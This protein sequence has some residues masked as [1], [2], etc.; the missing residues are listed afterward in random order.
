MKTTTQKLIIAFALC[1]G[2]FSWQACKERTV[3]GTDLIPPVDNIHTF[4][5]TADSFAIRMNI[6][7]RDSLRTNTYVKDRSPVV[8]LG[9]IKNDPFFGSLTLGLYTQFVPPI[10]GFEF[11]SLSNYDF[12]SAVL[13]MPYFDFSYG[14]TTLSSNNRQYLAVYRVTDNMGITDSVYTFSDYSY[15]P[16]PIATGSYTLKDLKDSFSYGTEKEVNQMRLK[17]D[18]NYILNEI[19]SL[20]TSKLANAEVFNEVFKGWYIAPLENAANSDRISYFVLEGPKALKTARVDFYFRNKTNSEDQRTVS[21]PFKSLASAYANR[22]KRQPAGPLM[23]FKNQ[24]L[25]RDSLIIEGKPGAYTEITLYHLNKMPSA[26][27]NKAELVITAIPVGQ[28]HWFTTPES[29][30]LEKVDATGKVRP[31]ADVESGSGLPSTGGANFMNGIAKKVTINGVEYVQYRLNLPREL[32]RS[33]M[34]G[35]DSLTLRIRSN[36]IYTGA[37]RMVA[38]GFSSSLDAKM[39]FSVIFTKTN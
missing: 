1:L 18:R 35:E 13:S 23:S 31:V 37:Y 39:Q 32:Q 28:D 21:F 24:P 12:D 16:T 34:A 9:M 15:Q 2:F 19:V 17:L 25:N 26:I 29:L 8:G 11:P 3:T 5:W 22:V 4:E 36:E 10:G 20:D 38:P 14:D 33:L 27:I 7:W 30:I 6:G